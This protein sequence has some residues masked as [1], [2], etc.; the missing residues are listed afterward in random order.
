MKVFCGG[1]NPRDVCIRIPETC[2]EVTFHGKKEFEIVMELRRELWSP[3]IHG[4]ALTPVPS[5][6]D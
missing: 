6:Y 2:Q 5:R 3:Q 4:D 1:Q